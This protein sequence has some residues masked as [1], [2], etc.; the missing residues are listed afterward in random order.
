MGNGASTRWNSVQGPVKPVQSRS[1]YKANSFSVPNRLKSNVSKI[2]AQHFGLKNV[3]KSES[4]WAGDDKNLVALKATPSTHIKSTYSF[5]REISLH[6]NGKNRSSSY[7]TD[8]PSNNVEVQRVLGQDLKSQHPVEITFYKGSEVTRKHVQTPKLKTIIQNARK[9]QRRNKRCL[10][11]ITDVDIC[12]G[13]SHYVIVSEVVCGP[14]L[15]EC[16]HQMTNG[17]AQ[18]IIRDVTLAAKHLIQNCDVPEILISV[19]IRNIKMAYTSVGS[20]A[21]LTNWIDALVST[22]YLSNDG[23]GGELTVSTL[24]ASPPNNLVHRICQLT[25]YL[26]TRREM[27][28]D[29]SADEIQR[30]VE[31]IQL[32]TKEDTQHLITFLKTGLKN[33]STVPVDLDMMLNSP[34]LHISYV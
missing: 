17:W 16:I 34:F 8:D 12:E 7:P 18:K 15:S 6:N 20:P 32:D 27:N 24:H 5:R 14:Y 19:D 2:S 13:E 26:L 1:I 4:S 21:V 33:T 22:D 28:K 10:Q 9:E 3:P 31:Q 25:F 29:W 30:E 23:T 11:Y